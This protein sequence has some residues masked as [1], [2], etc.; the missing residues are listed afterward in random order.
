MPRRVT[1]LAGGVGAARFLDGL[2]RV[3]PP[4]SITVIGNTG[5]DVELHGLTICPDL[6]TVIYSLAG[7][8]DQERGW[9]LANETFHAL[10]SLKRFTSET[11]FQLGDRD[12]ATHIYRSSLLRCGFPL[13]EVTARIARSLD[14]R[15][16][17][18]PMSD[19]PVRTWLETGAG[20]LDFQTYF[21][22]HHSGPSVRS[23]DFV[24]ADQAA[25]APGVLEAIAQ[26]DTV[27]LA[28]SNP[29][30]SIGPIL[31]VPGIRETLRET[32]APVLAISP[33]IGGKAVKGPAAAMLTDLGHGASA[34]AVANLYRD[35][36]D[37]FILDETDR[38]L[39][40]EVEQ[41][42]MR[43]VVCPT[44]MKGLP[45]KIALAGAVLEAAN[46]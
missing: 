39:R 24:G 4:E 36:V 14:I 22:K 38:D 32:S 46:S 33:I 30:I 44:I 5:D 34:S 21:V 6:D 18:L 41:L 9:G 19:N 7:L 42:G 37:V 28:P 17:I 26:A 29:I 40:L 27:I 20:Q 16:T 15:S 13:S 11:W 1:V 2:T 45:E 8:A 35:F 12:L 10:E 25:P 43:A 23:V 31:A 3:V